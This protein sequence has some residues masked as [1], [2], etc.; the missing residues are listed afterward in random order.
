MKNFKTLCVLLVALTF[1]FSLTKA[2]DVAPQ[3]ISVEEVQIETENTET[4][5]EV[6]SVEGNAQ[7]EVER[8]EATPEVISIEEG[9]QIEE[10]EDTDNN[11]LNNRNRNEKVKKQVRI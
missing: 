8:I 5:P 6:I 10:V 9:A 3:L 1:F 11:E 2:T 4:T 7:I